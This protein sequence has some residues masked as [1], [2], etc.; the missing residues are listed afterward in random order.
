MYK[1]KFEIV[2]GLGGFVIEDGVD[3]F[4]LEQALQLVKQFESDPHLSH[5]HTIVEETA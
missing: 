2:P 5:T 1:I 4:T 3:T